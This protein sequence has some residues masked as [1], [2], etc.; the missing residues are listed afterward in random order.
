MLPYLKQIKQFDAEEDSLNDNV[1][2]GSCHVKLNWQT[3]SAP[4][5][6]LGTESSY[7]SE[8]CR[9]YALSIYYKLDQCSVEDNSILSDAATSKDDVTTVETISE[10]SK[11]CTTFELS[12][13]ISKM[14]V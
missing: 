13:Q 10:F 2:A 6:I 9:T 14:A 8:R 4:K 12:K 3:E 1:M 5:T 11:R 7:Y